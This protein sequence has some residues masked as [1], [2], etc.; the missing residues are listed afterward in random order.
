M[1]TIFA[2]GEFN[3][4]INFSPEPAEKPTIFDLLFP[5]AIY[6]SKND[7]KRSSEVRN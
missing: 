5:T 4:V 3:E 1:R 7:N 2:L 6:S